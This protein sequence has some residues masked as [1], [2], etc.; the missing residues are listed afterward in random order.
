MT[1]DQ[2]NRSVSTPADSD[3][4]TT[5]PDGGVQKA[6]FEDVNWDQ[7]DS[8]S[9]GRPLKSKIWIAV[10]SVWALGFGGNLFVRYIMGESFV[11]NQLG[12][13]QDILDPTVVNAIPLLSLSEGWVSFPVIGVVQL[14]NWLWLMTLAGFIYYGAVPLYENPR[15]TRYYWRRFRR[16]K[17]AVISGLFLAVIFIIGFVGSRVT[18]QPKSRPGM[19]GIPPVGVSTES[20]NVGPAGQEALGCASSN[21]CTGTWEFPF[22]TTTGGEDI[23]IGV[24]HGM[25]ISMMVGLTATALSVVIAAAVALVGVYYGGLVDEIAFRWVDIQL[26]FP[27]F[28]LY[29]LLVYTIGGS[30]FILIFIFGFIEWGGGARLMRSEALQRREEPYITASKA[31]GASGLW[32]IRRHLLPNISNT[33]ITYASL[34]I[35]AIILAEAALSFL[36]LGDPTVT[37]WGQLITDGR[38]SLRSLW[39]VSTIP[40][41]FLFLTV[42]SFNFLGDALRDAIDPR[43]EG[44]E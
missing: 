37:S 7:I 41:V 35:P 8:E 30:L 39:W 1:D 15:M 34:S 27:A 25:E 43:H 3:S 26:T 5:T 20:Y 42:L 24:I 40:G 33:I 6:R 11:S 19:D 9:R 22:G 36:G 2:S 21:I 14:H 28:F 18:A 4:R 44:A 38:S 31:A 16:N 12:P 10:V 13:L 17:A 29:L 23:L 32:T